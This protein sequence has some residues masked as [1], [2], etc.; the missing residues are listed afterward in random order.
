MR[1]SWNSR[2]ADPLDAIDDL[3]TLAMSGIMRWLA[4]QAN[5]SSYRNDG[6]A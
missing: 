3:Y 6:P 1:T 2:I 4:G 5:R